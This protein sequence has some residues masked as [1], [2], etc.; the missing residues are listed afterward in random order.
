M[1][2]IIYLGHLRLCLSSQEAQIVDL[3]L[4][5]KVLLLT[6]KV[7][8]SRGRKKK[9]KKEIRKNILKT[10]IL[11]SNITIVNRTT[12]LNGETY[13]GF[14]PEDEDLRHHPEELG[15]VCIR[16]LKPPGPGTDNNMKQGGFLLR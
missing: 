7:L 13:M 4:N 14:A 5:H 6:L 16:L 2:N 3:I 8:G 10:S 11:V 9:K 1:Y 15:G 12:R